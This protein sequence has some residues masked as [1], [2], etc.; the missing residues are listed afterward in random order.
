MY[1]VVTNQPGDRSWP[2]TG[3][4]FIL[5]PKEPKDAAAA[6]TALAF[7]DWAYAKGSAMADE[8]DYV[9][10]PAPVQEQVKAL[11]KASIQS[12][13]KPLWAMN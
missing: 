11:W 10:M 5:M 3:A 8:L 13:G 9:A 2:I 7:F 4:S 6:K 12:E 1:L